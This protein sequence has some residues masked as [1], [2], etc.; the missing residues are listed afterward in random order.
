MKERARRSLRR[1]AS[2]L[3]LL[4][5]VEYLVVPQIAGARHALHLLGRVQPAWLVAGVVLEATAIACFTQLTRA[6]IPP[7]TRPPFTTASRITLST[8]G[9]SHVVPGGT[10]AG[11]SLGYRLLTSA[12]VSGPDTAFALATQGLGSAVVL[13]VLLWLGLV[14][15]I[16]GHGFSP[17]Y[18]TAAIIGALLLGTVAVAV[19]LA[20]RGEDRAV[21]LVCR[22][23]GRLPF[24]D[25]PALGDALRHVAARLRMLVD[26]RPLLWRATGWA[27]GNW[28]LDAASLWVFVRAFG[29]QPG[30][31]ALLVSFGLANVLAAI[32]ITPGGLGVVEATL[33]A[34]LVGFGVPRGQAVIGVV[35]Y[36]LANFWLPIPLGAAAYLSLTVGRLRD[37]RRAS[38]ALREAAEEAADEAPSRREWARAH[39]LGR[40][41]ERPS[42]GSP[43]GPPPVEHH[44]PPT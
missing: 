35:T 33:T 10:A 31:A 15:S 23:A 17:L 4:L 38:E 19:V 18:V 39:A 29:G 5:V 34:L 26:D 2:V 32:P 8:L 42:T 16:P 22:I 24:L 12:G 6:L 40:R 30:P 41:Q 3:V 21:A 20:T 44:D 11:A 36:R 9:A 25:G 13:N 28:L 14:A 1:A 37:R 27:A 7:P 43:T